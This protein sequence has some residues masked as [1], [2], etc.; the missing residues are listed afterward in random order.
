MTDEDWRREAY[1]RGTLLNSTPVP[2]STQQLLKSYRYAVK[3]DNAKANAQ[4][5]YAKSSVL[6]GPSKT[7]ATMRHPRLFYSRKKSSSDY[8]AQMRLQVVRWVSDGTLKAFGYPAGR[9]PD[10]VPVPV[11]D[12]LWA[13]TVD[14]GNSRVTGNG[15]TMEGVRLILKSSLPPMLASLNT[16]GTNIDGRG[17]RPSRAD[18][19]AEAY[20]ALSKNGEITP[21]M[22]LKV[23]AGKVRATL[24]QR[25][26]IER[27][28]HE[29]TIRP[30]IKPFHRRPVS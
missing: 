3:R 8:L 27:G 18:E 4:I 10:D 11:P 26:G 22:S 13:C 23:A 19:I 14:W 12:D 1:K 21:D 9:K 6:N 16:S 17:G 25:T 29:E 2:F 15:L 30:I 28:L 5:L 20:K 24:I 7:P